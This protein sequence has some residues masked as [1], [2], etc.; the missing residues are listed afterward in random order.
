MKRFSFLSVVLLFVALGFGLSGRAQSDCGISTLPFTDGFETYANGS[1][2]TCYGRIALMASASYASYPKVDNDHAHS[3][4]MNMRSYGAG[5]HYLILPQI[6][7]T[8]TYPLNTLMVTLWIRDPYEGCPITVG[9]MT[10]TSDVN[11][12]VGAQTQTGNNTYTLYTYY[13]NNI[14][15]GSFIALKIAN[16][17]YNNV[18]FDDLTV[19]VAPVCTPPSDLAVSQ[20]TGNAAT[21]N[22][23]PNSMAGSSYEVVLTDLDNGGETSYT[24]SDT[25]YQLSGL[26]AQTHYHVAVLANCTAGGVSDS[27]SA[28]F[29][30]T[31]YN[32]VNYTVGEGTSQSDGAYFP[33]YTYYDYSY[34]QQIIPA[35]LIDNETHDFTT[36]SFQYFF[37]TSYTRDIDLYLA[38]VPTTMTLENG[39]ITPSDVNFQLV[40]SGN[41]SFN[42]EGEDFW[43]DI[44]LDTAFAYNGTDN[45]LVTMYDHTNSYVSSTYKFYTHS[46]QSTV[47]MSRY[48][49]RDD[50]PYSPDNMDVDGHLSSNVNNIR[51]GYCSDLTCLRP[52]SLALSSATG[53]EATVSWIPGE[54]E[55]SWI[56][57]YRSEN[58]SEWHSAGTVSDD[59]VTL[60]SLMPNSL[61]YVHVRSIC[62]AS[63][64]V[65]SDMLTFTTDCGIVTQ[66]PMIEHFDN[67]V[68]VNGSDYVP[69]WSR[70]T[71]DSTHYVYYNDD[72]NHTPAG[73]GALDFNYTP[74]C[75]TMAVSP[76][77]SSN[78]SPSD[79]M[80]DFYAMQNSGAGNG[81]FEIGVLSDPAD[82]TTFQVYDTI[83]FT[84]TGEWEHKSVYFHQFSGNGQY[85]AFRSMNATSYSYVLDDVTFDYLPNCLPAMNLTVSNIVTNGAT[86]SWEGT[87]ADYNVY[88]TS[89]VDTITYSVT[90]TSVTLTGLQPATAYTVQIRAI[91]GSDSSILTDPY[92]FFTACDLITVAEGSPWV[93]DFETYPGDGAVTLNSCWETPVTYNA[94][95]GIFPAVY[96]GYAGAAYSGTSS[97]EMKG[98]SGMVVFPEFTNDINT[99]RLSMWGN[100][101]AYSNY[102]SGTMEV[103][104]VTNA[105]DP[106]TFVAMDTIP[107]VAFGRIGTA[108]PHADPIGPYGFTAFSPDSNYRIALRYTNI[109]YNYSWNFDDITVSVI[110]T[111]TSPVK[112]SV[113][114][115]NIT[116][117]NATIAWTDNDN[118][119]TAWTVYYRPSGDSTATWLTADATATSVTLTNLTASTYYDVYV[120]TNCGTPIDN[121]DATYTI[122]FM[123]GQN[124]ETLP[125]STDFT[126][127]NEWRLINGNCASYWMTGL[128]NAA[129][130]THGLF[131]TT[132]GSTPGYN[133]TQYAAVSAE[134]LF[135]IGNYDEYIIEFDFRAGGESTYDYMKLFFA[136]EN[137]TYTAGTASQFWTETT[138][139]NYAYNFSSYLSQTG[140]TTSVYK[141]NTTQGNTLH[142][143]AVMSNPH[144]NPTASSTAK[145]VFAW[146]NDNYQGTQPGAVI[147]NLSVRAVT[148]TAPSG[149]TVSNIGSN[150][151]TVTW[152]A[153]VTQSAW[154]LAYKASS[155]TVWDT[156][157]VTGT[158][159]YTLTGLTP[160]TDYNVQ[161]QADCGS[162]DVSTWSS[163][164]D[165]TTDVQSS[166]VQPTLS[167]LPATNITQTS[168]TL[169]GTFTDWGNQSVLAQG[170]EWKATNGGTYATVGSTLS[171]NM[172]YSLTGLT[173]S[174]S[175]TYRAFASTAAGFAYG[176]EVTF[177]TENVLEPDT[178]ETPT[179]LDTANVANESI[180]VT[181]TDNAGA[182]AWNVQYR[183]MNGSWTTETAN[184]TSYQITGLTGNTTY[185]IRV[186]ADCGENTSEWSNMLTVTTTNTG[187]EDFLANSVSLYPNPAKEVVNV[188]CT[189]HNAL[190]DGELHLFDVYGKLL[191]IIPMASETTTINVSGLANGIYFVRVATE[192]GV[193]T[194]TFVKQ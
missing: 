19:D 182:E 88:L 65:W 46:D 3:G 147:T 75:Y 120:V 131:I 97:M 128:E 170:F 20:V 145:L 98:Y 101:T 137:L 71:S 79:M 84:T 4:Y 22:W 181:W 94:D 192:E 127:N 155:A 161:V 126:G 151:A 116:A 177:T 63:Q 174:T 34:T 189:M 157:P 146:K 6:L 47:N 104:V 99:L 42:N 81:V 122:Q 77:L 106:T 45:I 68:S 21:L 57:E 30:T 129:D 176:E 13:L 165:F 118:T 124:P 33:T 91:C 135:T 74:S 2:P 23:S 41:V 18:Y 85:I 144:S 102:Y 107:P 48:S 130:N 175:Y 180:T 183:V 142:I 108:S 27:I 121:P 5:D 190:L 78:I 51:F 148:C 113:T 38:H 54:A 136:P 166:V 83:T 73:H 134:K 169:N 103:G 179:G 28:D 158:S 58:E 53:N 150:S 188:Q 115:S 172:T 163:V 149:L 8:V 141:I 178:C 62:G 66:L 12:F 9:A 167:T 154:N 35:A 111:C 156:V 25:T 37:A 55:T 171:T 43:F 59:S 92:T 117:D 143:T 82:A 44:P 86:L 36:V 90:G 110:P 160:E 15:Y 52:H 164:V 168:A 105:N 173:P 125:F 132:D 10:D 152:S 96:V 184:A 1:L 109:F 14:Q 93:E 60:T 80:V 89:Y 119:H 112:N 69:C 32:L 100:T 26:S 95:N 191:Q 49:Y 186:Q 153:P 114:A 140:Q 162:G 31:C 67:A 24:T 61:Y 185:E 64:S 56:V 39:W 123:T 16:T 193:V 76:E 187:I 159:T 87:A 17:G 133:T 29:T 72:F 70:L 50:T 194:K 11:S 138:Y 40:Y 139:S 7:D